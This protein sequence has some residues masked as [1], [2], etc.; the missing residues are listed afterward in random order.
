MAAL[1]RATGQ[2]GGTRVSGFVAASSGAKVG[3]QAEEGDAAAEAQPAPGNADE[4]AIDD[5]DD[6]D[7][8]DQ[9]EAADA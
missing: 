6:D 2:T 1:D 9:P 8:N 3:G 4:I 7:D 5:D